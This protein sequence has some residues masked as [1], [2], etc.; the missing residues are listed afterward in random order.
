[1]TIAEVAKKYDLT[2]DTLRYYERSGLIPPVE[3]TPGGI[4]NYGEG[5]CNWIELVKCMRGA[6]VS[7]EALAEYCELTRQG[8]GTITARK[9]LLM[10]ERRRLREKQ[11]ILQKTLDRLNYKIGRYEEAEKTGRLEWEK[12]RDDGKDCW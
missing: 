10:E 3:R 1:M 4:R 11:E 6:G 2:A 7:I 12:S 9:E 8:D 5:D